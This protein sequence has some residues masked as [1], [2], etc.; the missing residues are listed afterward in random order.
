LATAWAKSLAV[1]RAER[2]TGQGEKHL[3]THD[4]LK[5]KTALFI[6]PD[7]CLV[8]GNCSFAG[9]GIGFLGAED[10]VEFAFHG[11]GNGFDATGAENFELA[12]IAGADADIADKVV[13]AAVFD[14]Q[15]SLAVDG[16]GADLLDIRGVFDQARSELLVDD[17]RFFFEI[18][19]SN[20][21]IN[22]GMEIGA[23]GQMGILRNWRERLTKTL[24]N[25][26]ELAGGVQHF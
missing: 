14:E 24:R 22:K 25:R 18:E 13:G 11:D 17:E 2:T 8:D 19:G 20:Q 16:Q 3:L 1:R 7:F 4:I 21:H 26:R 12:F 6:I 15:V 5:Q 10:E 9:F 23:F